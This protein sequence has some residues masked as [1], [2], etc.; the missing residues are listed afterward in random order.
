MRPFCFAF[1]KYLVI[2]Q[3]KIGKILPKKEEK[4]RY[5]KE[6]KKS[7]FYLGKRKGFSGK[8]T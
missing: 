3:K 1:W 2:A 5:S 4:N 6:W 7:L 8:N